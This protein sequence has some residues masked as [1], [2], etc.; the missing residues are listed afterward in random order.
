MLLERCSTYNTL[1]PISCDCWPKRVTDAVELS[2]VM[3]AREAYPGCGRLPGTYV[4]SADEHLT[5]SLAGPPNPWH[6]EHVSLSRNAG[7]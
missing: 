7:Q 3:V 2:R 1:R 5:A 6:R 4:S